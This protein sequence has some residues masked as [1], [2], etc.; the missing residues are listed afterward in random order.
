MKYE[1]KI[2]NEILNE[3][4]Y[5]NEKLKLIEKNLE[6]NFIEK[7]KNSIILNQMKDYLVDYQKIVDFIVEDNSKKHELFMRQLKTLFT[8]ISLVFDPDLVGGARTNTKIISSDNERVHTESKSCLIKLA[9]NA[10][11]GQ[12]TTNRAFYRQGYLAN[13][14][15]GAYADFDEGYSTE[16]S[17]TQNLRTVSSST[18]DT[19][20]GTGAREVLLTGLDENYNRIFERIALNGTNAVISAK[21]YSHF[22]GA[23][24][25]SV[26]TNLFATGNI[27]VTDTGNTVTYGQIKAGENIW[28]AGRWHTDATSVGY[29]HQWIVGSDSAIVRTQLLASNVGGFPNTPVVARASTVVNQSAF[30]VSFPVP[31]RVDKQGHVY[32]RGISKSGTEVTTS[33]QL[34]MRQE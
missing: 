25:T 29:I 19:A 1:E 15:Q 12:V 34:T 31:I 14:T 26:G 3:L 30:Q 2:F 28:R 8:K 9:E 16:P 22:D 32:V 11:Y 18:N 27:S 10:A 24:V 6:K 13:L 33:F 5:M 7:E 23:H 4:N 17:S 21:Q 20:G